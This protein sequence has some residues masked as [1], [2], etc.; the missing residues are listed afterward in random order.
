MPA[1]AAE[2][3]FCALVASKA[4]VAK[5]DRPAGVVVF[6]GAPGAAELL[7]RWAGGTDR[8]LTLLE[9]VCHKVHKDATAHKVSLD[10]SGAPP[11]PAE[12]MVA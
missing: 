8:L 10:G 1:A 7:N 9:S 12:A 3:R 4:L 6:G 5:L 11:P 2:E